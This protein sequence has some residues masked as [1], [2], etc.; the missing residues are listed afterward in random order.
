MASNGLR[1]VVLDLHDRLNGHERSLSSK[2]V[3]KSTGTLLP[4]QYVIS[5]A[6]DQRSDYYGERAVIVNW[7]VG[8]NPAPFQVG[9][10]MK[11]LYLSNDGTARVVLADGSD[12]IKFAC[13][14]TLYDLGNMLRDMDVNTL[15]VKYEGEILHLYMSDTYDYKFMSVAPVQLTR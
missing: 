3:L 10:V 6:Y 14:M 11:I 1:E 4:P 15:R 12:F 13:K 2:I 7:V 5:H 8:N 9:A